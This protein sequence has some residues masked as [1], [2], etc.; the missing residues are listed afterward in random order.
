MTRQLLMCLA[1]AGLI[2]LVLPSGP[3]E[4]QCACEKS[5]LDIVKERGV[6][7]A[8][9]RK[10][11]PNFGFVDAKGEHQG[12]DIEIAKAVAEK[13]GV[14]IKMEPVT[15]Q[16]RVPLLQQGRIDMIV[17]TLTHYIRRDGAVDFSLGYFKDTGS[18]IVSK[19]SGIKTMADLKGKRIGSTTGAQAAEKVLKYQPDVKVQ[20][21]E[22][23][24][25]A[26]IAMEQGLVD[27][28]VSDVIMLAGLR[29]NSK[30]PNNYLYITGKD[31]RFGGGEY[32]IGVPENDSDWRDAIDHALIAIWNDGTWDKIF[33]KWLGS[34]SKIGF[35][36]SELNWKMNVTSP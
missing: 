29:M 6:V 2:G 22:A 12:F 7:I 33:N 27:G 8:G 30:N 31:S 34:G 11:V 24:S 3:A 18:V 26:F 21:F 36:K 23:Y 19:E 25:E 28:V 14:K 1:F 15:T 16:T 5:R 4:A 9:V 32:S 10:D 20:S 17:A 13:L 35:K